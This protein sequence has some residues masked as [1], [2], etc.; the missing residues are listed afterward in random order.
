M[1]DGGDQIR[2][3]VCIVMAAGT[4]TNCEFTSLAASSAAAAGFVPTRAAAVA[5]LET[6]VVASAK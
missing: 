6:T 4:T 2:G 3:D 5:D 1:L